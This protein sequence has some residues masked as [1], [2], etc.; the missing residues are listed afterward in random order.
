MQSFP[1][2]PLPSRV[3]RRIKD[4]SIDLG[5]MTEDGRRYFIVSLT[6]FEK[7]GLIDA[8]GKIEIVDS[9]HPEWTS[10][11]FEPTSKNTRLQ[12][13]GDMVHDLTPWMF[14]TMMLPTRKYKRDST[15]LV[16]SAAVLTA[17]GAGCYVFQPEQLPD[18]VQNTIQW[19]TCLW[20]IPNLIGG[21]FR[22]L[23]TSL[24]KAIASPRA[25]EL[26]R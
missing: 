17:L 16:T 25:K 18:M 26:P 15:L 3:H 24:K 4:L 5:G 9:K 8:N 19:Y 11:K 22:A 1:L 14:P 6:G 2:Q 20:G 12:D 10:A 7:R 13:I 23:K 21:T